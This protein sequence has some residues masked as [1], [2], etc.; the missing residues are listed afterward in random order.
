[1]AQVGGLVV[2]V[3]M[4]IGGAGWAG[5]VWGASAVLVARAVTAVVSLRGLPS[6]G[7]SFVPKMS[8]LTMA[9]RVYVRGLPAD[10]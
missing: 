7:A 5:A 9:A 4:F 3:A 2:G 1:M 10:A 6:R 8:D